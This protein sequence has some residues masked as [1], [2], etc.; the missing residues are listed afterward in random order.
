ML[1]GK[2][3]E[4]PPMGDRTLWERV[5][6]VY[7]ELPGW[8]EKKDVRSYEDLPDNAKKYI[9]F[10]CEQIDS[11]PS[12]VSWGRERGMTFEVN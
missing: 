1:D 2:K 6:P 4:L 11:E 8:E 9:K 5:E 10:V 12:L 7:V 3:L